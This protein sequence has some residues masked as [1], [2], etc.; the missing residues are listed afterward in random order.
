MWI[1]A[2]LNVIHDQIGC[3]SC[4]NR[5]WIVTKLDVNHVQGMWIMTKLHMNHDQIICESWPIWKS[6]L[7]KLDVIHDQIGCESWSNWMWIMIKL[8]FS[9]LGSWK[10]GTWTDAEFRSDIYQLALSKIS[11]IKYIILYF[12]IIHLDLEKSY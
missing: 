7:I 12:N 4:T 5:M 9:F 10:P 11:K 8:L 6:I 1:T 3:E 2:K